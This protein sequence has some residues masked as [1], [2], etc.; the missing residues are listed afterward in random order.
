MHSY[1]PLGTDNW[2][3]N[4]T[5]KLSEIIG[6]NIEMKKEINHDVYLNTSFLDALEKSDKDEKI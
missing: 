3:F 1:I 4:E 5:K 6:F 2:F